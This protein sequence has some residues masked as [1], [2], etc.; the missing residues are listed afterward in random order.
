MFDLEQPFLRASSRL[1]PPL[2]QSPGPL[3]GFLKSPM[4]LLSSS[5]LTPW[6]C[7]DHPTH[8]SEYDFLHFSTNYLLA[9][10]CVPGTFRGPGNMA[11]S[12]TDRALL[13][14]GSHSCQVMQGSTKSKPDQTMPD[15]ENKKTREDGRR[16]R[17]WVG[18]AVGMLR[19]GCQ[20][21]LSERRRYN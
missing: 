15:R 16:G 19:R 3:R 6:G 17:P 7:P 4:T 8:L 12:K 10:S 20:G 21:S 5:S 11:V 13:P 9:A 1:V 2:C 14:E 18:G